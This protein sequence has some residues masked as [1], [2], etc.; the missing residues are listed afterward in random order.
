MKITKEQFES[1]HDVNITKKQHDEIL[2]LIDDRFVEIC[3]IFL[4][5]KKDSWFDYNS[6]NGCFDIN[7]KEY[8]PI[9]GDWIKP[10]PGYD[11]D[12]PTRWLWEDFEDEMKDTIKKTEDAIFAAKLHKKQVAMEREERVALL[13]KSIESK[14]TPEELKIIKYK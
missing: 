14:L 13:K 4:I 2:S 12:F 10:R 8:I 1:L 6:E 11:L 5:M 9:T 3:K 7:W